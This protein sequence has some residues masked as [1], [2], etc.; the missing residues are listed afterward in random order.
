MNSKLY[1]FFLFSKF[2]NYQYFYAEFN[3]QFDT[4]DV[5]IDPTKGQHFV[6]NI[7]PRFGLYK[8]KGYHQYKI[9]YTRYIKLYN[10]YGDPVFSTK[11][12]LF[13][14]NHQEVPPFSFVYIGGED[15][16]RKLQNIC[17]PMLTH[18]SFGNTSYR[19]VVFVCVSSLWF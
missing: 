2:S 13:I 7:L 19:L 15:Y 5:Y 1:W 11:S 8:T 16:V 6:F 10:T 14:Q 12:E 9:K 3:Y 17:V 4:R 18:K